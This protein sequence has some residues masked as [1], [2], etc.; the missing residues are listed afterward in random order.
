MNHPDIVALSV[1]TRPDWIPDE[2]LTLLSKLAVAKPVMVEL[3]LQSANDT[4]LRWLNRGH[5]LADFESAAK[6]CHQAG[7]E[8]ITH[9]ILD[10]PDET[11]HDLAKTAACL[12]SNAIEGVKIHNLHVLDQTPL[13]ELYKKGMFQLSS[14][15]EYAEK[16]S[17]FIQMLG[18]EIIIHRLSGE[19][20]AE[21]M[22]APDWG[23]NKKLI[24]SEIT[25]ANLFEFFIYCC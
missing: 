10:L 21:L 12:N 7:L 23:R 17:E 22:L 11:S 13:A 3:G 4:F 19:G 5:S 6:R 24:L 25:K 2:V 16:V 20:P 9:V 15:L 14:L 8:V 18:V 1:G